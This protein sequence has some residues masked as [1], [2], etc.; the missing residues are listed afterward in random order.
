[1]SFSAP[2]VSPDGSDSHSGKLSG[3]SSIHFRT[4]SDGSG[5]GA[6]PSSSSSSSSSL[7]GVLSWEDFSASCLSASFCES[8]FVRIFPVEL[9]RARWR[10]CDEWW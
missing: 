2:Q 6:Q 3:N 10:S 1:M 7:R 4:P 8:C 9:L 5:H